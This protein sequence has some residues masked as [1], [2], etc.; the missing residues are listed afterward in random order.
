M[1]VLPKLWCKDGCRM[2]DL[3]SRAD[4]LE[5][6]KLLPVQLDAETVQRCIEAVSNLPSAQIIRCKDCKHMVEHKGYGY[7]G[8]SAYT[9]E[10]NMDGW[11]LPDS[12]CSRAERKEE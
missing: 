3:I 5:A 2:N 9:C 11:I 12:Y 6:I 10:G 8:E 4:A 1:E 7:L